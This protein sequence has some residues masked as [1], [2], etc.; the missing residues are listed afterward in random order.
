M[1]EDPIG[2]SAGV[3]LYSYVE[4][5]PLQTTDPSGRDYEWECDYY[6]YVTWEYV[7][8]FGWRP[9]KWWIEQENC[10]LEETATPGPG[11]K[12]RS[13]TSLQDT[14]PTIVYDPVVVQEI[15]DNFNAS[16]RAGH[17]VLS[18]IMPP[19]FDGS[20]SRSVIRPLNCTYPSPA[21]MNCPATPVPSEAS[22]HSHTL[23][24]I[25]S[26]TGEP[27]APDSIPDTDVW[28]D[29]AAGALTIVVTLD[30]VHTRRGMDSAKGSCPRP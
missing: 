6:L 23:T 30:S 18:W 16:L 28:P 12:S 29:S 24:G 11:G 15:N 3:N 19:G 26:A 17:E 8:F 27:W 20:P 14:C 4:G 9:K 7:A 25:D 13:P 22:I 2:Y 5:R 21:I 10:R 1:Q